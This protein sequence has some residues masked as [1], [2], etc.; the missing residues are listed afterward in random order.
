MTAPRY[1]VS[2]MRA[3]AAAR[4]D[5]VGTK[6]TLEAVLTAACLPVPTSS[7]AWT[8]GAR[9]VRVASIGPRRMIVVADIDDKERCRAALHDAV[10]IG[11]AVVVADVSSAAVTFVL[12]GTGLD[13]VL[14]QGFAHDLSP[15]F[16][17][18]G[19]FF[20]T[21][22]FGIATLIEHV[23]GGVAITVDRSFADYAEHMLCTAAGLP[24]TSKPGVMR[25]PPPPIR[26]AE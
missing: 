16:E 13:G 20:A 21:D 8:T 26:V 11:A 19:R 9:G 10:P 24:T 25:A 12:R 7:V 3:P 23:D 14:A 15:L 22:G 5:I 4:F 17:S 1:P 18:K 6:A 2:V